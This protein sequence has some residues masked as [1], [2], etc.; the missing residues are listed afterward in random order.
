MYIRIKSM[1]KMYPNIKSTN[2]Q[3]IYKI[4]NFC[5]VKNNM[6]IVMINYQINRLTDD[7]QYSYYEIHK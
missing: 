6:R 2:V 1:F 5:V 4:N 7:I 3:I